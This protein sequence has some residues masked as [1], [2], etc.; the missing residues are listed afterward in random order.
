[1]LYSGAR[2]ETI[3]LNPWSFS[4]D[5]GA[6]W[7]QG[8]SRSIKSYD[9]DTGKTTIKSY[10][11]VMPGSYGAG[12][13]RVKQTDAAGNESS[14]NTSFAAFIVD[15]TPPAAAPSL[16]LA[17]DTGVSSSDRLTNNPAIVVSALEAGGAW[18]FSGNSGT[19]WTKGTGTSFNVSA[20]SYTAGQVRVKQA[21]AAGNESSVNTSFAAFIVD[22]S[23]APPSLSLAAD[24]GSSKSDRLTDNPV[25]N[26]GG[27]DPNRSTWEYSLDTGKNWRPGVGNAFSVPKSQYSK[28]QV[29]VRQV[30]AAG[31]SSLANS[32]F[33]AFK[34][35]DWRDISKSSYGHLEKST[36]H[37]IPT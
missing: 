6:S 13:V 30:D 29:Q 19:T 32:G 24:T 16:A 7:T 31:N 8:T 25:I 35:M 9:I 22:T 5:S 27:L 21:D 28:G 37:L 36:I 26:I 18:H 34:I 20:G 33:D 23:S 11:G 12:Q 10:L 14:V 4:I 17:A 2:S 3:V 15:G 1:M